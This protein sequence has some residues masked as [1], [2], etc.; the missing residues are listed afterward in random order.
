MDARRSG[1]SLLLNRY[2]ILPL[3]DS[4]N[5]PPYTCSRPQLWDHSFGTST[6]HMAMGS[7]PFVIKMWFILFQLNKGFWID[8]SWGKQS[9]VW[10]NTCNKFNCLDC[11]GFNPALLFPVLSNPHPSILPTC[12]CDERVRA[13]IFA[14][15]P[16]SNAPRPA[17]T[18]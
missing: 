16:R 6:G 18:H 7:S 2:S 5:L 12:H 4:H 11:V 9:P 13:W 1:D 14:V 15:I 3:S 8:F 10:L 17:S